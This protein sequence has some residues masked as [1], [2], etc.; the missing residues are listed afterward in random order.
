MRHL[1]ILLIV[2][3]LGLGLWHL[4]SRPTQRRAARLLLRVGALALVL[5]ALLV[6]VYQTPALKLL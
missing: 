4:G 1:L 2:L 5:L 3:P 6:L